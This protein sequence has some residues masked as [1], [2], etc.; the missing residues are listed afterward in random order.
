MASSSAVS[1]VSGVKVESSVRPGGG[2]VSEGGTDGACASSCTVG[3]PRLV[4]PALLG[5]VS[6]WYRVLVLSR[7]PFAP[8]SPFGDKQK[9]R[10]SRMG[11]RGPEG[12]GLIGDQAGSLQGSGPRKAHI[13][14]CCVVCFRNPAPAAAKA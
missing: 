6:A 3:L 4:G 10:G 8:S 7:G 9:G 1:A 5:R 14:W 11:F 12:A 2:I 13:W